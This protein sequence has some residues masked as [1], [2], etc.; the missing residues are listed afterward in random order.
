MQYLAI[1]RTARADCPAVE[2][3][4]TDVLIDRGDHGVRLQLFLA[5]DAAHLHRCRAGLGDSIR[6]VFRSLTGTGQK[7]PIHV[8]IDRPQFRVGLAVEAVTIIGDTHLLGKFNRSLPGHDPGCQYHQIDLQLQLFANQRV[9]C[10][11]DQLFT[12][13]ESSHPAAHVALSGALIELLVTRR[14]P[15]HQCRKYIFAVLA[16]SF[17]Q[18][19]CLAVYMQQTREQS[20]HHG[21]HPVNRRIYESDRLWHSAVGRAPDLTICRAGSAD[22]AQTANPHYIRIPATAIFAVLGRVKKI[23]TSSDHDRSLSIST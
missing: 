19:T 16:C 12:P 8:C 20:A 1:N 10:P 9:L 23:K 11:Q 15:A 6:D 7:N 13:R 4:G 22:R 17:H 14:P 3:T 5:K 2:T 18:H 21:L